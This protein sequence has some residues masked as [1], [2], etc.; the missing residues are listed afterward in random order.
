MNIPLALLTGCNLC[1][2]IHLL[3]QFLKH[4]TVQIEK[5]SPPPN[6]RK[7]ALSADP[8]TK[9]IIPKHTTVGMVSK[10][11]STPHPVKN[12]TVEMI[13]PNKPTNTKQ[14]R[15]QQLNRAELGDPRDFNSPRVTVLSKNKPTEMVI[16]KL[17]N[18]HCAKTVAP[19]NAN[20]RRWCQKQMSKWKSQK[21]DF[22]LALWTPLPLWEPK[23]MKPTS[24]NGHRV[25]N[26]KKWESQW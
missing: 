10:F 18:V 14:R 22:D 2:R 9:L 4:P 23:P 25:E 13:T 19:K 21:W 26:R 11:E 6:H 24:H 20:H 12:P 15:H 8:P 16:S 7:F 17:E 5:W 1:S 3:S